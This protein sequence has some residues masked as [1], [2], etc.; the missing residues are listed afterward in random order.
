M[1]LTRFEIETPLGQ[2]TGLQSTKGLCRLVLGAKGVEAALE[3]WRLRF[4]PDENCA[5]GDPDARL[6]S[7]LHGYF[8]GDKQTPVVP[9][10]LRGSDFQKRVWQELMRV[11]FGS[12]VT[13]K[14]I[15]EGIASPRASQAVGG[16]NGANPVPIFVPCH[17][18]V[19]SKGLGGFSA[20]M[21]WKLG[22]LK[23]EGVCFDFG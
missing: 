5:Q 15:A 17:R 12:V 23:L 21:E 13:Y 22:L 19:S 14:Q 20:P 2:V 16:A 3:E 18:V 1:S 10:D 7:A 11:P 9:L 6:Q 4:A 8:S